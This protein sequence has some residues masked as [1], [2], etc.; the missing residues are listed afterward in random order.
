[1]TKQQKQTAVLAFAFVTL[2]L[3]LWLYRDPLFCRQIKQTWSNS[4]RVEVIGSTCD[5][6]EPPPVRDPT[7]E[8]TLPIPE[9]ETITV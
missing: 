2:G 1:M 4:G 8:P 9:R 6:Y 3:I 7:P 5:P